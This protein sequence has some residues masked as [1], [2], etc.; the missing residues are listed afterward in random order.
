MEP[1]QLRVVVYILQ[2]P[3]SIV[4]KALKHPDVHS[5]RFFNQ[6]GNHHYSEGSLITRP[7]DFFDEVMPKLGVG[8]KSNNGKLPLQIQGPLVPS[9]ITIDG[10]LSSQFLT[11]LLMAYGTAHW[12]KK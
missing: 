11:G 12:S 10:S 4:V 7:M 5:D 1:S 2:I 6:T 8:I 9:D 3:K